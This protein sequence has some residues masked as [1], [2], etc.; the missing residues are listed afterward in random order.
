MSSKKRPS[1]ISSKCCIWDASCATVRRPQAARPLEHR[2]G[3]RSHQAPRIPASLDAPDLRATG[4]TWEALAGTD[5]LEIQL[6][7]GHEC[8][9][10]TQRY[11]RQA[12]AVGL[13][14]DPPF[15]AL[16]LSLVWLESSP[17]RLRDGSG[18]LT[19]WNS[20]SNTLQ[21]E[22]PQ[23]DSNPCYS[24]ERAVSWAGL[25]DGDRGRHLYPE[26]RGWATLCK[27]RGQGADVGFRGAGAGARG[28]PISTRTAVM[29]SRP[30]RRLASLMKRSTLLWPPLLATLEISSAR[31]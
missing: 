24:L 19:T 29:L 23:R 9:E 1:G 5:P 4:I 28:Q 13:A 8:F 18:V 7:A 26:A 11:V 14:S 20:Y 3:S 25:D 22:R 30:P 27:R 10:T 15:P 21:T 2:Y 6:R 17:T 16:P 31:R 12:E